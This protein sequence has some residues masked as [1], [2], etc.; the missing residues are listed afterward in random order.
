MLLRSVLATIPRFLVSNSWMA[1]GIVE[2][3]EKEFRLFLWGKADGSKGLPLLAW[4]KVR[5][6]VEQG[7][8]GLRSL[9]E[10]HDAAMGKQLARCFD[11][12]NTIWNMLV[13]FKYKLLWVFKMSKAPS[14]TWKAVG[15]AAGLLRDRMRWSIGDG[16]DVRRSHY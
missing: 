14:W 1:K 13:K 6:D 4:E 12:S 7:G 9:D 8:L 16:L 5:T 10:A 11:G 2:K 15:S 3:L